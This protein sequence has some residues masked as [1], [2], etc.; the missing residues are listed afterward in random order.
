MIWADERY[1]RVYT[2]DTPEWLCLSFPAQG[3]LVLLFRK[4][5]RAGR[6]PLGKLGRKGVGVAIGHAHQW[7]M[8]EPALDELLADGCVEIN[9]DTLVIPNFLEAQEAEASDKARAKKHREKAR[10]LARAGIPPKADPRD[11][12]D[13]GCDAPVTIRDATVTPARDATVTPARDAT[14]TPSQAVPSVP[15]VPTSSAAA[16]EDV[17]PEPTSNIRPLGIHLQMQCPKLA[18]LLRQAADAGVG[19]NPGRLAAPWGEAE[20]LIGQVGVEAALASWTRAASR[21][22][23]EGDIPLTYLLHPLRDAAKSGPKTSRG[24]CKVPEDWTKGLEDIG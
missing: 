23:G 13:T 15:P 17:K 22:Q 3:L 20:A 24:P 14:V 11:G 5:D 7:T 12:S 4:V 6:L 21:R 2:R 19:V 8:L 16:C 18:D 9:G 10:D 1:V